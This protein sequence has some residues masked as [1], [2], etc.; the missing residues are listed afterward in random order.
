MARFSSAKVWNVYLRKAASIHRSTIS[1]PASTFALSR[2]F[3]TRAG[4]ITVP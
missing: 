1:T 3:R 2:G 4:M